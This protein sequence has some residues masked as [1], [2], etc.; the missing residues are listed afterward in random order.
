MFWEVLEKLS[1]PISPIKQIFQEIGSMKS[2]KNSAP[3]PLNH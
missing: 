3:P 1:L 2:L